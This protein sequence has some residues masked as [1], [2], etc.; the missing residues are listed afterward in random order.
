MVASISILVTYFCL[1]VQY[2]LL[3]FN[4]KN[5]FITTLFYFNS[6]DVK[7]SFYIALKWSR[8]QQPDLILKNQI[9]ARFT[10]SVKKNGL[11]GANQFK[12]GKPIS[13]W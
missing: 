5:N 10:I 1:N 2:L 4:W 12:G 3:K 13:W 6:C 7:I 9:S 8:I 11:V